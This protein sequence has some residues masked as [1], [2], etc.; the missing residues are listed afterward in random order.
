MKILSF[1]VGIKNLSFCLLNNGVIEDWGI[2]NICTDDICEHCNIKT[3]Q[4][5]DKSAKFRCT[6][7]GFSENEYF[8]VCVSHKKLKQYSDKKFKGCPKKTNPMLDQGKCIVNKLQQKDNFL[9]VD[10]VVI[11]NQPA[12][13]NPTMK[14]IQMMIYSYFLIKGISS[15]TSSIQDIQMI[16]ARNKLKAYKG[17]KIECEIKDKYKRTKYLGIEYCKYMI[18]ESD[19]EDVWIQLFNQSKKKDDLADAYLQGMYVLGLKK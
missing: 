16:N 9:D 18:S 7:G 11:E 13:K 17:P 10:L 14:S 1:D 4:R 3:G 2:L 19:Q 5:C 12:L 15:D 8:H 6:S